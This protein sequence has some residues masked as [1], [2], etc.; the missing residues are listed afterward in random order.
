MRKEKKERGKKKKKE[1]RTN[2]RMKIYTVSQKTSHLYN[3]L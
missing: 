3:L 1:E 2:S